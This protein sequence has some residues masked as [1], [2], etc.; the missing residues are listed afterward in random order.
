MK[1]NSTPRLWLLVGLAAFI[2]AVVGGALL[3]H[4]SVLHD[5]DAYFH[6]AVG[7]AY[8]EHGVIDVLPW[9][10]LSLL[11]DGFGD[12]EWFFHVF[13]APFAS[14]EDPVQGGRWAL[15]VL[16]ALLA[17]VIAAIATPDLG[18]AAALLPLW[19][20]YASTETTWRLVRLR[21]ELLSLLLLLLAVHCMSRGRERLLGVIALLYTLSYTAFHAL[22]GL[23]GLAFAWLA[24]ARPATPENPRQPPWRML[25]YAITG[26]LAGLV[27]HPHFPKNLEIWLIQ[28]V[29]FF[30][31]KGVL[32][33]GT[34]IRPNTSDV[35]LMVNLGWI[36]GLLVL[37]LS[38]RPGRAATPEDHRLADVLGIATAVFGFLY[39]LMSRF[40]IYFFPFATLFCLAE[41]RRRGLRPGGPLKLFGRHV[42]FAVAATLCLVISLP[43]AGRQWANYR[44]RT[45]PG[46]EN[47]RL[48]DREALA[49]AL[50]NGA[51]VAADWGPTAT[52]MLWAPHA[53]YLNALDPI[54][55]ATPYP[56][57]HQRLRAVLEGR[58]PDIPAAT[59]DLLSDH[60]AFPSTRGEPVVERL[61][62]D[63]RVRV[64]HRGS[65]TLVSFRPAPT[66]FVLDW[67][68]PA[69]GESWPRAED[70]WKRAVEGYVNLTAFRPEEPCTV[71]EHV[72]NQPTNANALLTLAP[73]GPST[74]V[75]NG[76]ELAEIRDTPR[77]YVNRG[78]RIP[79]ALNEGENRLRIRTC[80]AQD[81][82]MKGFYLVKNTAQGIAST[83]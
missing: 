30:A 21:P 25:L 27:L 47:A 67:T 5:T 43:E 62:G 3:H 56:E 37:W 34:E 44:H 73:Y 40:S 17:A 14:L 28:N 81:N 79:A 60:L 4:R 74:L 31:E 77:A 26:G 18:R 69:N 76:T 12:K 71:V 58:A 13:L 9:T 48:K 29:Q 1:A 65:H 61:N 63:P 72:W 51:R 68:D 24:W 82:G 22:L 38:A 35:V 2:L 41:M 66:G 52:Y 46:P 33:V 55:M 83:E 45:D 10:R 11:H 6:L 19:I 8:A 39:L 16:G 15:I 75:L 20:F 32:D 80:A 64:L 54:F 50:P 70:P 7:R 49:R 53:L 57:A 23:V 36:L 59:A 78:L 42:P